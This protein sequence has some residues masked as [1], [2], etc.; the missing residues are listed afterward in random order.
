VEAATFSTPKEEQR[1]AGEAGKCS[2]ATPS[3]GEAAPVET[4]TSKRRTLHGSA[5]AIAPAIGSLA[6][7]T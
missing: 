4:E 6:G 5:A 3:P 1:Y 2:E 7:D